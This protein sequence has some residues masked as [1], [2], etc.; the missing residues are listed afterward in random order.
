LKVEDAGERKMK[1]LETTAGFRFQREK[2]MVMRERSGCSGLVL[3]ESGGLWVCCRL[4]GGRKN[5]KHE[6][7]RRLLLFGVRDRFRF[8]LFF[9]IFLMFPKL[10]PPHK[11]SI[12]WYL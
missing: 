1:E 12:A 2:E 6:G 4:L 8:R 5:P 7:G 9:C 10:T 11:I 3:K